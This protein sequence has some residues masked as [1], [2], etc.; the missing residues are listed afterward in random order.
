MVGNVDVVVHPVVA[1]L[2]LEVVEGGNAP[3][4]ELEMENDVPC[5]W[6]CAFPALF[7]W[8]LYALNELN[9]E[10]S[11]VIPTI[12][13]R[14]KNIDPMMDETPRL[15]LER[16]RNLGRLRIVYHAVSSG[17][18]HGEGIGMAV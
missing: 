11:E 5:A 1:T 16:Q 12:I 9:I 14:T 3:N 2:K 13:I 6:T 7:T 4:E 15:L 10:T 17:G 18:G 8:V